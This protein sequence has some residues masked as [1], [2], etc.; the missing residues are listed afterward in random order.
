MSSTDEISTN[1]KQ[2]IIECL[3]NLDEDRLI[4]LN[5]VAKTL[6]YRNV[7]SAGNRLRSLRNRYGFANFEGKTITGKAVSGEGV[8]TPAPAPAP[9]R[10]RGRPRVNNVAPKGNAAVEV[11]NKRKREDDNKNTTTTNNNNEENNG[12]G[13]KKPSHQT[14]S[15]AA[16]T[17]ECGATTNGHG[18]GHVH[19]LGKATTFR[20]VHFPRF[21]T[22]SKKRKKQ[23]ETTTTRTNRRKLDTPS[24][25]IFRIAAQT[26][27]K[28]KSERRRLLNRETMRSGLKLVFKLQV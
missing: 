12:D 14:V 17:A 9:E 5:K 10:K 8:G 21:S 19:G 2:F 18:H 7:F 27:G 23:A 1:D 3:K 15:T 11:T 26:I 24:R 28:A 25:R 20:A 4:N 6:G 13:S 16:T 22:P